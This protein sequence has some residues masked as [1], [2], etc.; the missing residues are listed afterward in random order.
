MNS[1]IENPALTG[2]IVM[3]SVAAL[4]LINP[5][6]HFAVTSPLPVAMG[7]AA[8]MIDMTNGAMMLMVA[9]QAGLASIDLLYN[10]SDTG[11]PPMAM[12]NAA[13]KHGTCSAVLLAAYMTGVN[14]E[15]F[16]LFCA[17]FFG[18]VALW[19]HRVAT[20]AGV[21]LPKRD[22]ALNTLTAEAIL[23]LTTGF[24]LMFT[25][26]NPLAIAMA[27]LGLTPPTLVMGAP[28]DI[29]VPTLMM[30]LGASRLHAGMHEP[31]KRD[32]GVA[33]GSSAVITG[34]VMT[35]FMLGRA[36]IADVMLVMCMPALAGILHMMTANQMRD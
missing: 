30:G 24:A 4:A 35:L 22:F 8:P 11:A 28:W 29:L 32:F 17:S 10:N 27:P 25:S 3:A 19:A 18:M 21:T 16:T 5:A 23:S 26:F 31:G 9:L 15:P 7:V 36:A 12:E 1:L 20:A 14:T 2:G 13:V 6:L 34:I 33:A